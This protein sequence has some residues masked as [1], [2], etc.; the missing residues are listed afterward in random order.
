MYTATLHTAKGRALSVFVARPEGD[1]RG[2]IVVLHDLSGFNAHIREVATE[3]F[4]AAGYLTLAPAFQAHLAPAS[5]C[6]EGQSALLDAPLD[7]VRSAQ[8][9]LAD[10]LSTGVVGYGWGSTLACLC[11][12]RLALP[13][14]GYCGAPEPALVAEPLRAPLMLHVGE[15]DPLTPLDAV[16]RISRAWPQ[17]VCHLYPAG[18]DFESPDHPDFHADSAHTALARTLAFFSQHLH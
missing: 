8:A 14:V 15:H 16:R 17:S 11:A 10:G 6:L 7:G 3:H 4:A 18:H 1:P 13:A 9:H 5:L 12:T 2:C